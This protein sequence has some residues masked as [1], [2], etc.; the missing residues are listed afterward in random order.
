MPI[1]DPRVVD[2]T[3]PAL[4]LDAGPRVDPHRVRMWSWGPEGAP[5]V[6]CVHALTG[7]AR[8]GGPE[9]WWSPL[10][11]PGCALDPSRVRIVAFNNLGSR[12]GTSG[13]EDADW[14]EGAL[15]G[16]WDQA[17][18][19]LSA[20]DA[21]GIDEV[22]L[23]TGGSLGGMIS[24]ALAALAPQRFRALAPIATCLAA[25]AWIVG[26]NHV[27]R[28][29]VAMDPGYPDDVSRG[30]AI[31][32]QV[33]L[34]T[35]RAE[36]GLDL[37]QGRRPATDGGPHPFAVQTYLEYQGRKFVGRFDAKTYV[38]QA[39]AM[40]RHDL[41]QPPVARDPHET[42]TLPE[43]PQDALTRPTL[44]IGIATDQLFFPSHMQALAE[45]VR[46]NGA[47]AEYAEISSPHGHDAFLI[48]WDQLAALLTRG[49][50]LAGVQA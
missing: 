2:L 38:T 47:P 48:E 46:E 18:S 22:A 32:R 42:W 14:P 29:V 3:L 30:L 20:L 15:V 37:R 33:A 1:P 16:T 4:T 39:T 31:A 35:Y 6:L 7:D 36:P 17:R 27:Q 23:L 24:L 34:L 5:V 44:A 13:P 45:R 49:L 11:G 26:F 43:D 25:S 41:S 19:L 40:D 12:Y 9:G 50:G 28:Q 10:V 21:A 8:V